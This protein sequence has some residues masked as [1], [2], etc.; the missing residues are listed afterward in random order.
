MG[1]GNN[2]FFALQQHLLEKSEKCYLYESD[3]LRRDTSECHLPY[4]VPPELPG[5]L[6]GSSVCVHFSPISFS[7]RETE[8]GVAVN[9]PGPT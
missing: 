6:Q 2:L 8:A 3:S 5:G 9:G 7:R 1:G 4:R